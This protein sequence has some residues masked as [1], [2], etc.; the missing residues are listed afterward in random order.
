ME[1]KVSP[2]TGGVTTLPLAAP[3]N[4]EIVVVE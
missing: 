3:S 1:D 2:Y 4:L